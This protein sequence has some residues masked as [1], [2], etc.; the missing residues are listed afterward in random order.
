MNQ[1]TKISI[2]IPC[3]NE[4]K[5]I[6]LCLDNILSVINSN[7]FDSEVIVV[8]NGSNDE[9]V[10]IVEKYAWLHFFTDVI[11]TILSPEQSMFW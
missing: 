7:N 1:R 4:E 10:N 8:D 3:L 11:T 9:S 2:I 6:G 5:A